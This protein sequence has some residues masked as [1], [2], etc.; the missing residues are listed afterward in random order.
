M[1]WSGGGER[2][3]FHKSLS[4]HIMIK[5]ASIKGCGMMMDADSLAEDGDIRE[6]VVF[7]GLVNMFGMRSE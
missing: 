5:K 7:E 3:E 2:G 4:K 6:D 1:K